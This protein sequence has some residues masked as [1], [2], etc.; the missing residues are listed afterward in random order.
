MLQPQTMC[1]GDNILR[2]F[3]ENTGGPRNASAPIHV[4][5]FCTTNFWSSSAMRAAE[6]HG[7]T[8][9]DSTTRILSYLFLLSPSDKNFIDL[10]SVVNNES[11]GQKFSW[12]KKWQVE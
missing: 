7:N 3:I 1:R 10:W 5:A 4:N 9:R 6:F 11:I 8:R 12:W 2:R